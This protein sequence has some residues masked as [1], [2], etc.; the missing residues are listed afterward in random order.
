MAADVLHKAGIGAQVMPDIAG[1]CEEA[2]HGAAAVLLAAEVLDRAAL[3]SLSSVLEAQEPWSDLPVVLLTGRGGGGDLPRET[4]SALGNVTLLERPLEILTL[5][6]ALRAAVRA[7]QRQYGARSTLLE[8]ATVLDTVPAAVFTAREGGRRVSGNRYATD[9]FSASPGANLSPR[10][11]AREGRTGFRLF[12]DGQ[13][14]PLEQIPIERAIAT[15]KEVR[16]AEIDL[17]VDSRTPRHLVGS[18][19]PL[20]APGGDVTGAVAAFLD[21][22]EQHRAAQALRDSDRRKTEFLA[23]L[24]HE[25]RNPLAAIVNAAHLLSLPSST[26][27]QARRAREVI[28]RQTGHLSRLVDDLLDLTRIERGKVALRIRRI[29]LSETVRRTC[30]DHQQLFDDRGIAL[31]CRTSGAPW[32]DADP[33]RIAQVIGNLLQNAARYG[34]PGGTVVVETALPSS[35]AELRVRDDGRGIAPDLLQRLFTPFVRSDDELS[36]SQGGLGLGL[37]LVKGLVE[38]HG[39]SVQALSDGPGRGAEF[40]LTLPAV[41]PPAGAEPDRSSRQERGSLLVLL[42]EDNR[43]G[44]QMLADVLA[45]GG[46]RVHL[47]PDGRAAL[48]MAPRLAP[49]VVLCD[50]GLPD[51]DG[52][53]LA[54][55]L[56]KDPALAHTRLIALS[57]YAQKEDR[58][59]AE[60]A[61]FE[62]HLVKPADLDELERVLGVIA[63]TA[64]Q[65]RG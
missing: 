5:V 65:R 45:S 51:M 41:E 52:Y 14:I 50:I 59:R 9:L 19:A 57:G 42:V 12:R 25:L 48:A 44:A 62:A 56:R 2:R 30:D 54:H 60:Q 13:E 20:R 21:I 15:G 18:A 53:A 26:E 39:G 43:D 4:L 10:V 16:N 46:H 37:F 17:V 61:G 28:E 35:G 55:A 7:R 33:T 31:R 11:L 1:L 40:I 63:R 29:D 38:L 8:L 22:T 36:R 58:A 49:D 27:Q 34:H 3:D 32:I 24:S 6:S 47:A 64:G 23:V